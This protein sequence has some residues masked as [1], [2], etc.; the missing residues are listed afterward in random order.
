MVSHIIGKSPQSASY[1]L[2]LISHIIDNSAQS[3]ENYSTFIIKFLLCVGS[4]FH[5]TRRCNSIIPWPDLFPPSTKT[6]AWEIEVF[7]LVWLRIV[8]HPPENVKL[9]DNHICI[10]TQPSQRKWFYSFHSHP[11]KQK[12]ENYQ[13]RKQPTRQKISMMRPNTITWQQRVFFDNFLCD[14]VSYC[15]I[16]A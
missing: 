13:K 1:W 9:N 14:L 2:L 3:K 6:T 5:I 16:D 11:T 4:D 12:L 10:I 7:P 8:L 15:H